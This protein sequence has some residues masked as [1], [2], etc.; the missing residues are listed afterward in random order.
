MILAKAG[1]PAP[2][3][4][5]PTRNKHGTSEH[6]LQ[7][8]EPGLRAGHDG[9]HGPE[10]DDAADHWTEQAILDGKWEPAPIKKASN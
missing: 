2:S 4:G 3:L 10:P 7:P 1:P 6:P 5:S 8:D 9:L